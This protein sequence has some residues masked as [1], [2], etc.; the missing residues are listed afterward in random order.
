MVVSSG[1]TMMVVP[2][3][4]L[5]QVMTPVV[6][7]VASRVTDCPKQIVDG[8]VAEI[9]GGAGALGSLRLVAEGSEVQE[10]KVTVMSVKDPAASPVMTIFPVASLD[11][12]IGPRG[13][14]LYR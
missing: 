6:H 5:L 8:V 3:M 9:A 2:V 4:P 11:R 13:D 7:P 1:L 12:V 10:L 14:P